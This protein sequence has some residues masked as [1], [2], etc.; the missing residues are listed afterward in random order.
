MAILL[1][2]TLLLSR[3]YHATPFTL[4]HLAA[5]R[6]CTPIL[7]RHYSSHLDR[8]EAI[9][10]SYFHGENEQQPQERGALAQ[11]GTLPAPG[12][13][14]FVY[15]SSR[16]EYLLELLQR[17]RLRH[18]VSSGAT[19]YDRML[20]LFRWIGTRWD[21]GTDPVPGGVATGSPADIIVSG[22]RGRRFWC[23]VCARV[24][25][26]TA[27][28]L[29]WPA[30]LV[31][32]SSDGYVWEHALAEVW[33]N[34]F[35]KWFLVDT[36]YNLVYEAGGIPLS[37]YELCHRGVQL[38]KEGLLKVRTFAPLKPSLREVDLLHL[39]RYVHLDMR[40]DWLSRRLPP[41]SPAGGDLATWWTARS[42]LGPILTEK[43]RVDSQALFDWPVNVVQVRARE[44]REVGGGRYLLKLGLR[45]YSPYF[46]H[47]EVKA[48]GGG[49][50]DCKGSG[51]YLL[52][53]PGRHAAEA[54]VVTENGDP[55]PP[56]RIEFTL[57]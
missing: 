45:C 44:V 40:N 18:L 37:A 35:N 51:R 47:F 41:G 32:A 10:G 6:V 26:Q 50:R 5:K 23:E 1:C 25:V 52:L 2:C 49:W 43:K 12:A 15:E 4:V 9:C 38:K 24:T 3:H 28:A 30:R 46:S 8:V 20:I 33:S 19:E 29:G 17:F 14:P 7:A 55:G 42:D 39:Y 16:A 53:A 13:I 36:D 31:T 34:Q 22:E 54:R 57:P 27:T 48:D 56:S 11:G 21:H